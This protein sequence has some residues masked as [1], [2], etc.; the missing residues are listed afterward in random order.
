MVTEFIIPDLNKIRMTPVARKMAA[1]LGVDL[2]KVSTGHHERITKADV[3]GIVASPSPIISVTPL[4]L[5]DEIPKRMAESVHTTALV[6]LVREVDAT[7]LVALREQLKAQFATEWGFAPGYNDLLAVIV[8]NS[9]RQFSFMNARLAAD[10]ESIE[11][12][13]MVNLGLA[14]DTPRGLLVTVIREADKLGLRELGVKFR[15]MVE[16]ARQGKNSH[17]ELSGGTFTITNL[18]M[19]NIDAFTPVINLPELAILGAG[20]IAPKPMV[21]GE[22]IVIRKMWT[23]SLVFDHRLVDG[24]SAARFLQHIS[25]LIEEPPLLFL[26]KR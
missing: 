19:F 13:A 21:K 18:G 10:G 23:L 20:R 24:A 6:T 17:D 25:E 7:E 22:E 26:T 2:A 12:L 3:L 4:P 1:D 11:H 16:R 5:I 8:A 9:L 15:E 14:V